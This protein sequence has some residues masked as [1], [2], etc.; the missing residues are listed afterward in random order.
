MPRERLPINGLGTIAVS[1]LPSGNWQAFA[2]C[3]DHDG[4]RRTIRASAET[5]AKARNKL[6]AKHTARQPPTG[7]DL[8]RSSTMKDAAMKW[9]EQVDR[10]QSKQGTRTAYRRSVMNH[11]I[12]KLG[13]LTLGEVSPSRVQAFIDGLA[14]SSGPTTAKVARGILSQIADLCVRDDALPANPVTSTKAPKITRA[15][16][17]ALTPADV[18]RIREVVTAWGQVKAPGPPR[19]APLLLDFL[20]VL[21]GT[22]MRPGE[23]LA[24][25]WQD[26]DLASRT[27]SVT[28]TL[29]RSQGKLTRQESPKS[30]TSIRTV[31]LP[32]FLVLVLSKR[33]LREGATEAESP[34]FASRTGGWIEPSN[35]QRIWSAARGEETVK[36]QDYRKAVA[37]LIRRAEGMDAAAS[38]LGH[39][40]PEITR[41][42]YVERDGRVDFAAVVEGMSS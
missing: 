42:H 29:I 1:R 27:V 17:Q 8:T 3:R 37:T 35:L 11:I 36:F 16:T 38:Q 30:A 4:V 2:R 25:R 13:A 22:G 24:L 18:Q 19:N 5:K 28:G 33:R 6:I 31:S 23:A 39:S 34:V 9:L 41:R 12:P 7:G 10:S 14:T 32:K 40:S 20:D 21:A 15:P 26:V